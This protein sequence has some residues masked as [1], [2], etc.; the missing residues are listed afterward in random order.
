MD[1]TTLIGPSSP[2]GYPAPYWFLVAFK[3]LGFTL[4]MIPMHI[5]YAGVLL[6]MLLQWRGGE[7]AQRLSRR[8]MRPMPILIALGINFGIVPLLFT[9]V[10]YYKVFYPATILM[11]WPWVSIIVLLTLAYYG[12]YI[13]VSGLRT[14]SA[15]IA[16]WRQGVGWMTAAFF[17]IIGF[18]FSN[19]FSLMTNLRAW[20]DLWL[21]DSI[22]GAPLGTVLNT[23]D[24]TLWPRWLM[25][26]ALAL[27]TTAVF[28]VVDAEWFAVREGASYRISARR[29][30]FIVSTI[31]VIGFA[32]TGSW[33]VFGT[34]PVELQEKM[35]HSPLRVLTGLTA[36]SPG[37]PWL[38]ILWQWRKGGTRVL[39]AVTALAQVL[40]L[41]LNAIS[42]Q[43]VQNAEL[44]RFLDVTAEP[45]RIEWSPLILFL[46]L[47]IMG[48]GIVAW[49]LSRLRVIGS[50]SGSA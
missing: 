35:L 1:P 28:I 32:I 49:M 36:L 17:L 5:W 18:F 44:S 27:T 23:G 19:A 2:L 30:A 25:M 50:A 20:P 38:L 31:G 42:R 14:E 6:A 3:V 13:Y 29:I 45:V 40:V 48:L 10:A 33:Y 34:W 46:L 47:F 39:A 12:V 8:L 24:P 4:H 11:A 26:F 41:A 21:R 9:Q 7:E 22:S 37:A 16:R 43:I 15:T